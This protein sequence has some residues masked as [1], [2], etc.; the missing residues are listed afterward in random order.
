MNPIPIDD[1]TPPITCTATE[2]ELRERIETIE[3]LHEH[4]V[5]VDRTEHGLVLHFPHRDDLEAEIRRFAVEE[6]GCCRFWGFAVDVDDDR[7]QLRWDGP[8]AVRELMDRLQAYFEG[9]EPIAS[10]DGLL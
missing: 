2:R 7:L 1:D 8:P 10:V 6:Q 3:R 5:G 4:L 9:D